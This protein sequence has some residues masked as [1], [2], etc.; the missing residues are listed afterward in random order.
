MFFSWGPEVSYQSF[1]SSSVVNDS[2]KAQALYRVAFLSGGTA[3]TL[4][5][6]DGTS[7]L[8]T[9][10]YNVTGTISSTVIDNPGFG[11]VFPK[12]LYVSFDTNVT[13]V[14]TWTRQV[15]T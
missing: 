11:L 12:G 9:A 6:F 7:S 15:L 10:V 13:K 1:S 3:G 14:T 2:G 5:L 4:T 8:G